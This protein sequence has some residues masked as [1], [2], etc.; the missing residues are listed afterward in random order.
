MSCQYKPLESC[1]FSEKATTVTLLIHFISEKFAIS[2]EIILI[3]NP[4]SVKLEL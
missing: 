4:S 1:Q 2:P 3:L